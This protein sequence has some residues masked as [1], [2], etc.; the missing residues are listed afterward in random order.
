MLEV[1]DD[2]DGNTYRAVYTVKF[3]DAVFVLHAFQSALMRGHLEGFSSERLFRFLNALG[4]DVEIVIK[5]K[6][7]NR[8]V[9]LI[10]VLERKLAS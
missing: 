6:A 3:K 2:H 5:P 4:R 10:R 1:V 8:K 7:R 9:G